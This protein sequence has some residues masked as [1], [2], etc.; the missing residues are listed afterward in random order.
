MKTAALKKWVLSSA[1]DHDH[2]V[3]NLEKQLC[4][5]RDLVGLL[6]LE[7]FKCAGVKIHIWENGVLCSVENVFV[8]CEWRHFFFLFRSEEYL[9]MCNN[10]LGLSFFKKKTD[11]KS[12]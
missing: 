11:C 7:A 2:V 3:E 4:L 5:L 8:L 10:Y 9:S 1:L 12:N 6:C